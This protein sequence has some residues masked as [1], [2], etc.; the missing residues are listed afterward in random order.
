[1]SEVMKWVLISV[2]LTLA[3]NAKSIFAQEPVTCEQVIQQV[4][5]S[6]QEQLM[7]LNSSFLSQCSKKPG[8]LIKFQDETGK[9]ITVLCWKVQEV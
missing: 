3:L 5:L 9:I 4:E 7:K 1:M 2:V 6:Y 8:G